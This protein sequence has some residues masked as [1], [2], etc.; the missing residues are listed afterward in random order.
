MTPLPAAAD[1]SARVPHVPGT[2]LLQALFQAQRAAFRREAPPSCAARLESLR[3]LEAMVKS[4]R[5][6]IEAA[7]AADFG[8]HPPPLTAICE[9]LGPVARAQYTR[10]HLREWMKPRA[11]PASRLTYGLSKTYVTCQPKGVVGNMA[12]WNFPIDISIGPLVDILAAGNRAIVKPSELAPASAELVR[13]MVGQTFDPRE[14]AVVTGGLELAQAFARL[15]WDHLLFTGSPRV[16]KMV[17]RA[18]SENLTPV[19]LEL[20]GKCPAII[21]ADGVGPKAVADILSAKIVKSGQMCVSVDYVFVP[22]GQRD[23]FVSL[24]RAAMAKMLPNCTGNPHCTGIIDE[25]SLDRLVHLLDDAR[26][27]GAEVV[28]LDDG[29]V[30]RSDRKLPFSLVLGPTDDM[31]LMR[32]EIF[33]P[34]L[35]VMTYRSPGEAIDYV[36]SRERPLAL[37]VFTRDRKFAREVLDRTLSGGACVNAAAIHA[38]VPSM[39]FGGIGNSGMG[40]HHGYEGFLAFSHQRS[41]FESGPGYLSSLTYP[42]YGKKLD[43]VLAWLL[44]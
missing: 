30:N 19:T 12:P 34:I 26:H 22:E 39:P 31:E 43:R 28:P 18:A 1:A 6:K 14:V 16:G 3:A 17:M 10:A 9:L 7:L 41:I 33:G 24:A 42:P 32:E 15:P 37:Y 25:R 11:R 2:D 35:P 27:K 29:A 13:E 44:R 4:R 5:R 8:T 38:T 21:A 20:G 23:A 40:M 36:N